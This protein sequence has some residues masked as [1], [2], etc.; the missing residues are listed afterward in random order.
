MAREDIVSEF[1]VRALRH[2]LASNPF[3]FTALK[4]LQLRPAGIPITD[5]DRIN[6]PHGSQIR[7]DLAPLLVRIAGDQVTIT[8]LGE[9]AVEAA[10]EPPWDAGA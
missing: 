7:K 2:L 8:A 3:H 6:A 9:V 10:N 4:G 1:V 5:F